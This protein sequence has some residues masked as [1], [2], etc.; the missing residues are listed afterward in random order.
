MNKRKELRI[1]VLGW[2]NGNL[3]VYFGVGNSGN[4]FFFEMGKV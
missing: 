1:S 2:N 4:V 3:D